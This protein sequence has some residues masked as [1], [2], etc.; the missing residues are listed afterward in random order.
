LE[1]VLFALDLDN[2]WPP[3]ASEGVLC[4]RLGKDFKLVNAPFFIKGL[5]CGDVFTADLDPVNEHV[6]EFSVLKESGH[7]LV[8]VLNNSGIEFAS[9]RSQILALECNIEEFEQF[10]LFSIDIPPHVDSVEINKLLDSI[11]ELGL[12]LAFPVWRHDVED[13]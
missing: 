2:D 6:F 1:K 13:T 9:L 7:S 10:S 5:A 12:D 4:E 8:W 3:V 11:E